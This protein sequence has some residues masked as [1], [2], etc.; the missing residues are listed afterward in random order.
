MLT[1]QL[2]ILGATT[3]LGLAALGGTA[4]ADPQTTPG[5]RGQTTAD[6]AH[7]FGGLGHATT[8]A[9]FPISPA[10]LQE[11]E[12]RPNCEPDPVPAAG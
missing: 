4:S 3:A 6:R 12:I 11:E 9:G 8:L 5:C 10:D 7:T 1:R 2:T